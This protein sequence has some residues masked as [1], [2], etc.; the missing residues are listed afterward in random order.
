MAIA[1]D[2]SAEQ[3]PNPA[4]DEPAG[5]ASEEPSHP[6]HGEANADAADEDYEEEEELEGPAAEAAEREKMQAVFRRLS[7]APVGIRVHEVIIKGNSKTRD[8]L[9][10]AEVMDLIRSA[11]TVQD[12]VG[13]ASLASA[14]LRRLDVFDSV[15]ITL[16]AGPPELPG[17]TNVVVEVVE[18]AN[19]IDGS[20]GCISKPEARSWSLEGSIKLKN[21][22]GYGD[23]WDAS[24]AYGWDQ[25]SKI[26]IGVSLPRFKSIPTPLTARASLL[27]HDWLKFSSYKERLCGLS[28]GFLSTM[29]HDLSYNLTWRTLTDPSQMASKSMRRQLGHNLLSALRYT[30]TIDQRDSHLRPTKGY[31]FVST[32]QVV[33]LWDSKGLKF[34]RQEFDVCR[35]VPFGYYNAALNV[36]ISAGVI[37]PL[38]REFMKSPS[39]V[40]DRF[41]LGGHSS[42]VCNLGGLTSLL[43]FK[44]RGV[45]PTE[46]RRFVPSDSVMDD[47]AA[48]PGQ[49]YLG[50]DLVASAFADLS[51]DLPLKLFR[52]AGIHAHAFLTAGN[53]AKLS[54]SEFR[55]FSFSEFRGT[56]RSSAGVGIIL[57]TKLLRLEINYCYI[58]KKLEHDRGKTGIQFS[59]SSPM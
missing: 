3:V 16:D 10:E 53:V 33:G 8:A 58:L 48:P 36:G 2:S 7:T 15:Y 17:T 13:A 57:P 51:F 31:A 54:E 41:F 56:F 37:L 42:P 6:S 44:T 45:S 1:A 5:E 27:S 40:P 38:G 4:P 23:I 19:P 9:I 26:G 32:S 46:L 28:F 39:P 43:G 59:F 35:A 18:A 14:R 30:Y 52:D 20:V 24:G 49:D 55:N 11:A 22:F 29:H 21:I 12:L 50:G 25:S 47:S 34:F